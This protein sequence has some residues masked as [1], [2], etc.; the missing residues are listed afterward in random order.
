[1]DN[2]DE[3][4]NEERMLKGELY[5]AFTPKL[6]AKRTRCQHAC[7]RFNQAGMLSRRRLVELWRDIVE[8]KTP[9]PPIGLTDEEDALFLQDDPFIDGPVMADYGTNLRYDQEQAQLDFSL[10]L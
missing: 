1:M 8:D 7:Q 9:L 4:E 3:K 5:Y 10:C 2:I 6:I